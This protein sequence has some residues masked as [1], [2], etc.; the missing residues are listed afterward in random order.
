MI[1]VGLVLTALCH[2]FADAIPPAP[3]T[4]ETYSLWERWGRKMARNFS[5]DVQDYLRFMDNGKEFTIFDLKSAKYIIE[6]VP[7]EQK[8][9]L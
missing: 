7:Q 8:A 2:T 3:G 6:P 1:A 9:R 4:V 5:W